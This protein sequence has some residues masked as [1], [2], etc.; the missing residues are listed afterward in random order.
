MVSC[1]WSTIESMAAKYPSSC[2][3]CAS[4]RSARPDR[5]PTSI[6]TSYAG[7]GVGPYSIIATSLRV[8]N[9]SD[10]SRAG[11]YWPPRAGIGSDV[12]NRPEN[13]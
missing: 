12:K 4:G 8:T 3:A 2:A 1:A 6:G 5:V 7:N 9:V 13:D 11:L 10:P